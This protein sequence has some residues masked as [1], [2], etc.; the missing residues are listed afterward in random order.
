LLGF[1]GI[2]CSGTTSKQLA[3]EPTRLVGYGAMLLEGVVAVVSLVTVMVLAR[4]SEAAADPTSSTPAGS[5]TSSG[6]QVDP[7][8]A[9]AFGLLAFTTFV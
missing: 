9:V 1:H 2:V 5:A 7:T 3:R 8:F 4:G 6:V